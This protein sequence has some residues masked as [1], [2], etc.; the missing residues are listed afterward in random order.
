MK[1]LEVIF[2][3]VKTVESAPSNFLNWYLLII[4]MLILMIC[5]TSVAFIKSFFVLN[6]YWN[7]TYIE[8]RL[9]VFMLNLYLK[10]YILYCM[11]KWVFS[12][13][14]SVPRPGFYSKVYW[15]RTWLHPIEFVFFLLLSY[16]LTWHCSD[17]HY[18]WL[19]PLNHLT[20]SLPSLL[21]LGITGIIRVHGA[22]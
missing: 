18:D 12:A 21:V 4:H 10:F 13:G 5:A 9:K 20:V 11:K 8:P 15:C 16:W 7:W 14:Q 2:C 1:I 19:L 22:C 6:L 3:T 17:C